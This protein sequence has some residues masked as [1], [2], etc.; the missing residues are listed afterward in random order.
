MSSKI[1]LNPIQKKRAPR[2]RS[3][4]GSNSANG[5]GE[6]KDLSSINRDGADYTKAWDVKSSLEMMK[7]MKDAG[8]TNTVNFDTR[9]RAL[10]L[11]AGAFQGNDRHTLERQYGLGVEGVYRL[12]VEFQKLIER[13]EAE[14]TL[15]ALLKTSSEQTRPDGSIAD[16]SAIS[17]GASYGSVLGLRSERVGN[18]VKKG[19]S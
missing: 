10:Q 14:Q 12:S 15:E 5:G 8:V 3:Q 16:P 4:A 7:L 18:L 9:T 19:G 13:K 17:R 2:K 11:A 6:I 1:V